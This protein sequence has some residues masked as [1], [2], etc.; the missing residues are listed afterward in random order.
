MGDLFFN[1]E[2][3]GYRSFPK[4]YG[5]MDQ[6]AL[7][8]IGVNRLR[9]QPF[10][11]LR[12]KDVIVGFVDTGIDYQ[13]PVFRN[14]DN[15]S[16]II[17]IW[18]Q[19]IPGTDPTNQLG[20][21]T[22]YSQEDLNRALASEDP[23][24]V[25][26]TVDTIG[27]GTYM[28][29][30][31][32]GNEDIANDFSGVAPDSLIAMVKLKDAKQYLKEFYL[33]PEEIP[34][35][36]E[37]DIM[38]GI[39]YLLRLARRLLKPIVICIGIGTNMGNHNGDSYLEDFINAYA[40]TIGVSFAI[41]GG[42][43]GNRAH[44]FLGNLDTAD[45]Y[46]DVE[47]NVE[48]GESGFIVEL[49][50]EVL[51][52]FS[53]GLISPGGEF[54]ERIPA[55][56]NQRQRISFLLEPTLIYVYYELSER[57]SGN[58]LIFFR[59]QAPTPG[60]WKIRVYRGTDLDV[61]YHMWLPIQQFIQESTFFLR[62]NPFQTIT[63]PGYVRRA[64]TVGAFNHVTGSLYI[65]SGRGFSVTGVIKPD[66][67]AP[68]VEVYGPTL[69]QG[70]G[71]FSGTSVSAAMTVGC[72]ALLFDWG[73]TQNNDITMSGFKVDGFLIRGARRGNMTYP[74]PEWGYGELDIYNVFESL[75][76]TV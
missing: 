70:Y 47:I 43:E 14:A 16:R 20:Y 12:G 73:I 31:A 59:F 62:S 61:K 65:N 18:D 11:N 72:A 22:I 34:A 60:I 9:R 48:E 2:K 40:A 6:S 52:T 5:L 68:G 38:L 76:T 4:I 45:A 13:H 63:S 39:I 44:H 53:V 32:A 74:N 17:E 37:N 21:G 30:I 66:I 75:R 15:T 24:S 10:L 35:Y 64:T 36:Q 7:E 19:S 58:E 42:N 54:S 8:S 51:N 33:I 69:G 67:V 3:N 23:L 29:G 26:P 25:V 27:H 56:L 1:F 28:A 41:A 57:Q 50:G 49:W 55:R 71:N 46:E